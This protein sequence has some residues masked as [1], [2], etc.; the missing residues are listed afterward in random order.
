[1][2]TF[3]EI[4]GIFFLIILAALVLAIVILGP[5]LA[6]YISIGEIV[7]GE[8]K[9]VQELEGDAARY[10]ELRN[11]SCGSL[12]K[13]F[14]IVTEDVADASMEGLLEGVPGELSAA[15]RILAGYSF[16]QTTK[17][18]VR[19]DQ[20]KRVIIA[21]GIENTTVW[22][23]GRIYE[24][25]EGCTMHLMDSSEADEYYDA[26]NKMKTSCAYFG[27]T[28][29]PG[30]VNLSSLVDI[31][32]TGLLEIDSYRCDN[33]LITGNKSYAESI[34]GTEEL[35]EE[36]RALLWALAHLEGP[37]QECLDESTG[38]IVLRNLTLD[39]TDAYR[40]DYSPGGYVHVS[41]ET[42]L[43]YFT[44]DVPASFLGLPP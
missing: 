28:P 33:F 38:I 9:P 2:R 18:Y 26:L 11:V 15:E 24:C 30:S 10:F 21:D 27:K 6:E 4:L 14:L 22:K 25:M 31:T 36:Q 20:M 32:R 41:Q 39:L 7:W 5:E 40:F 19:G 12:S 23:E 13:D 1:M 35:D 43:L 3:L 17:T 42:T 8:E 16:N 29:L 34:L 44:D 37:L